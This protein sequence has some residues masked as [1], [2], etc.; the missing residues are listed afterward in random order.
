MTELAH[1]DDIPEDEPGLLEYVAT[2][3]DR[4][5]RAAASRL[6]AT[7][8]MRN[9]LVGQAV[10]IHVLRNG[11][12]AE[13]GKR[14]CATLSRTLSWSH[15][16]ELLPIKAPAARAFYAKQA[17]AQRLSLRELRGAI[18]RKAY[19]RR[20]I[21]DSQIVRGSAVPL[22]TFMD[23]YLLEFL[24]LQDTYAERD[25]EAAVIREVE[26]FLLEFG[27]GFAFL[28]RQKRIPFSDT[29]HY[30]DLLLYNRDLRR[31]VAVDFKIGQFNPRDAGQMD[32]YLKWLDRYERKDGEEAPIGLILVARADREA[33]ELMELHKDGI[34]VAEYWTEVLP[35]KELQARLNEILRSAREHL[36]RRAIEPAPRESRDPEVADE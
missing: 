25:L 16:L 18:A 22:D 20:E 2:L 7:L 35:K 10:S 24:G 21:A 1:R 6:N 14:I 17:A 32:F 29:D 9:W 15:I 34:M 5:G 33:L 3:I 28:A 13:Y 19:E 36:A 23:P 4:A 26:R 8:T 11:G 31:L 30:L 12:H 27:R